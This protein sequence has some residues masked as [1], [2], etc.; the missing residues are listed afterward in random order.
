MKRL[1]LARIR[2]CSRCGKGGAEMQTAEGDR[3]VVPLDAARARQLS[4]PD[5]SDDVRWLTD[6]VLDHLAPRRAGEIVFDVVGGRLRAL[7]SLLR[8]GEE[9]EVLACTAEEGVALS[10]RGDLR[11]YATDDALAYAA[12][13]AARAPRHG[14]PDTVH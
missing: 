5:A 2:V 12:A 9:P 13:R 8:E 1:E 4:G 11:L 6:F 7:L 14:G 10:V 3:L